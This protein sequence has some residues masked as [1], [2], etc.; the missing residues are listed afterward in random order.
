MRALLHNTCQPVWKSTAQLHG[1]PCTIA[2][3]AISHLPVPCCDALPTT[4]LPLS[5]HLVLGGVK[6]GQVAQQE[7]QC[8][9]QLA[10]RLAHLTQDAGANLQPGEW[11]AWR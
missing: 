8:A 6:V 9:A 10:V 3:M 11:A 5:P 1:T 7:A 4:S 2:Q